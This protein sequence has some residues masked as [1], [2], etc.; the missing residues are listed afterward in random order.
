MLIFVFLCFS[1]ISETEILFLLLTFSGNMNIS[2]FIILGV[3]LSVDSLAASITTGACSIKLRVSQIIRVA[4]YMAAFQASMP[5]IGWFIGSSFKGV[6]AAYDHWIALFLLGAIGGKLIYDGLRKAE[7][8]ASCLC[9]SNRLVLAGMALATSVDA[10]VVGIG[11]G[12][13]NINIWMAVTVIGITTFLFSL[14]GVLLGM[15]IGER[16]NKGIEI[17]GG[18]VLIG[19]GIHIFLLHTVE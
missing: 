19:L 4:F 1:F 5:L 13:L 9:P 12:V 2:S 18:L 7:E 6:V 3:G 11:F 8:E 15:S 17:F 16:I 14:T 10:L